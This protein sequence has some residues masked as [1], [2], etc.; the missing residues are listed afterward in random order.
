[1]TFKH[2]YYN[3]KGFGWQRK[4]LKRK[5]LWFKLPFKKRKE[6]LHQLLKRQLFNHSVIKKCAYSWTVIRSVLQF[7]F[8]GFN[9]VLNQNIISSFNT[10]SRY[11]YRIIRNLQ[12]IMKSVLKNLKHSYKLKFLQAVTAEDFYKAMNSF[13]LLTPLININSS[14]NLSF[15]NHIKQLFSKS[16]FKLFIILK[17]KFKFNFKPVLNSK[18]DLNLYLFIFYLKI[19]SLEKVLQ[20][21]NWYL[22]RFDI[23]SQP[24]KF[25][26]PYIFI[27]FMQDVLGFGYKAWHL[28]TFPVVISNSIS[29][30]FKKL[31]KKWRFWREFRRSLMFDKSHVLIKFKWLHNHKRIL[32]SQYLDIYSI[33]IQQ[34]LRSL[35]HKQASKS[36]LFSFLFSLE[37][38]IDI[39]SLHLFNIRTIRLINLFLY[40][41]YLTVN[42]KLV[43]K[44]Y[45]LQTGDI[46]FGWFLYKNYNFLRS[47]RKHFYKRKNLYHYLE[48]EPELFTFICL[49]I[50][51]RNAWNFY[52]KDRII[53]KKFVKY[54]YLRTY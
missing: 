14:L 18:V 43:N 35:Y 11:F 48:Y 2:K 25:N 46:I 28:K 44:F 41:G 3:G 21:I 33:R 53:S 30:K 19:F 32:R 27:N 22:F 34:K 10:I 8:K 15:D 13:Q 29:A 23:E 31:R 7:V 50:P 12:Q 36:R 37:Y 24:Y 51:L 54:M 49:G 45:V 1:M 20:H 9:I 5:G 17:N 52:N 6:L 16:D 39:L 47:C 42:Y 38:R 4:K 26:I 40:F